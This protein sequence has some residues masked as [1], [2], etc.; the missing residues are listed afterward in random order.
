[1]AIPVDQYQKLQTISAFYD[2]PDKA[3]MAAIDWFI[4]AELRQ[5]KTFFDTIEENP[6]TPEQRLAVITDEDATLVL[7]AAGSGKTSVIV[8]KA[9]YLI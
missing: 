1:M 3:R 6:L 7:A 5:M 4:K 8:A 2:K 9:A